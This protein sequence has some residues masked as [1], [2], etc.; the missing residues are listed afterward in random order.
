MIS[1]SISNKHMKLIKGVTRLTNVTA[2][3]LFVFP[4]ASQYYTVGVTLESSLQ[5]HNFLV[6]QTTEE[7]RM[8][9]ELMSIRYSNSTV[10]LN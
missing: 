1:D 8:I 10:K 6:N 5:P 9:I 2:K 4:C 3:S 7:K